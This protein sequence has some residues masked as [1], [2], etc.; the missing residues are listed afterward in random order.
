MQT[1]EKNR[2]SSIEPVI[3]YLDGGAGSFTGRSKE[4]VELSNLLKG[5]KRGKSV[6]PHEV[7]SCF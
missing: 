5:L 6:N 4:S 2:L 1:L 7:R 3:K